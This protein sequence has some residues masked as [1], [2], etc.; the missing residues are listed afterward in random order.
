[1]LLTIRRMHRSVQGCSKNALISEVS[2]LSRMPF[3]E[4]RHV[5]VGKLHRIQWL[6]KEPQ[7]RFLSLWLGGGRIP[8]PD[9][10]PRRRLPPAFQGEQSASRQPRSP[11]I[12]NGKNMHTALISH[13]NLRVPTA[14]RSRRR[15][16]RSKHLH[17]SCKTC[18]RRC[19]QF[20]TKRNL[21][22]T[23]C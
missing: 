6:R 14:L 17:R 12:Q 16:C 8:S 1:M 3:C 13:Y 15:R 4:K 18:G 10:R 20:G 11:N 9:T 5:A 7:M 22:S 2:V 21:P 23:P 19:T